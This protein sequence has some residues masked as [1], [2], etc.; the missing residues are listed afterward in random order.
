LWS[1]RFADPFGG[2]IPA[3]RGNGAQW[4]RTE[5]FSRFCLWVLA[6]VACVYADGER[7]WGDLPR[8]VGFGVYG[9]APFD[10]NLRLEWDFLTAKAGGD[11][12]EPQSNCA[13]K[14]WKGPRI[15]RMGT[16]KKKIHF[17]RDAFESALA[18]RFCSRS[19]GPVLRRN[20][21][22]KRLSSAVA[23]SIAA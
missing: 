14:M 1:G 9:R 6:F 12:D 20:D 18:I 11:F 8:A 15:S 2:F 7:R 16:D 19:P 3:L 23:G 17:R 13:K 4:N 22:A 5:R 21:R 10:G